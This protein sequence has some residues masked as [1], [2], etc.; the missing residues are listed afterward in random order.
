LIFLAGRRWR[1][2]VSYVVVSGAL[3]GVSL[4]VVG[5]TGLQSWL[6]ILLEPE[7][8]NATV[9]AWRMASL[10]SFFDLLLPRELSIPLGL[11]LSI[12]VGPIS[13]PISLGLYVVSALAL[14]ASLLRTWARPVASLPLTWAFTSLVAVLVDPHLVDYDLTVLVSAG[15]VSLALVRQVRWWLVL[16]YL[17]LL[18]RVQ[19]PVGEVNIQLAVPALVWCAFLVHRELR[20]SAK[21][22][23][24]CAPSC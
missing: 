19:L 18:L 10:K 14:L 21:P 4:A 16:L 15:I 7:S 3:L 2:L 8:G 12:P 1:A 20:R 17:L 23:A 6:R 13:L 9:N 11:P 24:W 22:A 5:P